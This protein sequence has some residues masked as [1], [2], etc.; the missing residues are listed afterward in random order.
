MSEKKQKKPKEKSVL[1][2]AREMEA[3]QQAAAA[4]AEAK[5]RETAQKAEEERRIAYEKQLREERLELIRLKQGVIEE[6]ETIHEEQEEQKKYTIWQKIGN[7]FYHNKWWM[8]IGCFMAFV[9]GFLIYS[10]VTTVRADL[11][12]LL[13]SDDDAFNAQCSYRIEEIFEQYIE[14]ENGDGEISVDVYYIPS[15]E[16]SAQMSGFTGDST[17]LFAEF[18]IGES[19]LVI[20]DLDADAFIVP[21]STLDDLEPHFGDYTQT[22][23]FRFYL[24]DTDFAESVGWTEPLDKDIYIGIRKVKDTFSFKEEMQEN[25]DIAFPALRKFIEEFGT[26]E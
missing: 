11:V 20:S 4:E 10:T 6:S 12:V 17:K 23:A 1:E 7:F 2:I 5:A 16:A 18:Q 21:D 13:V 24:H 19:L 22:E 9:V 26:K 15:S 25:Y 3:Q 8:G 14:D